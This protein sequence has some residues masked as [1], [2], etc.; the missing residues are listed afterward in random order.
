MK[1]SLT[2]LICTCVLI[3]A[4]NLPAFAQGDQPNP[5]LSD[6]TAP[7]ADASSPLT[8]ADQAQQTPPQNPPPEPTPPPDTGE[9]TQRPHIAEP[10]PPPPKVPDVRRPGESGYF[11]GIEVWFPTQHPTFDRGKASFF[12][13]QSKLTMQGKPKFGEYA[14]IGLAV[15]LHNSLKFSYTDIHAPGNLIAPNDLVLFGHVY[16]ARTYVSNSYNL[17]HWKLSNEFLT[18]PYPVGS[19]KIRLKTLFQVQYT[20]AKPFFDAPKDYFDSNGFLKIDPTTTQPI[21]LSAGGSL[22]IFSPMFGLGL[23]YYPSRH[24]RFELNGSGF[25]WPHRY[26]VLDG[27]ASLNIRVTGHL[28]MHVG[29][30]A[31]S[32]KTTTKGEY[33]MKG[34]YA[35]A[36]VGLRW[37][38]NS[39]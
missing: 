31:F 4:V 17:Q 35:S 26:E 34:T 7:A 36:A 32:F 11:A 25:G 20:G 21:N 22:H 23:A 2:G 33:F 29:G 12:T 1:K 9:Q 15:G 39:E 3:L 6:Y 30:R 38:S 8:A 14:E 16:N 24:F 27:D 10:P 37:Y 5:Q 19:R 13:G 28:E 18:W